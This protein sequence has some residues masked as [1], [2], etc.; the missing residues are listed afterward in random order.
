MGFSEGYVITTPIRTP[1]NTDEIEPVMGEG[2]MSR[3][4]QIFTRA[5]S[6]LDEH[7]I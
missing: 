3:A 7:G 6:Y 2:A 1:G 4:D 5:A